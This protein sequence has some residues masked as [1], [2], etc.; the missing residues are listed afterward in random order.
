MMI[1]IRV[2]W[3]GGK[4][5]EIAST[6]FALLVGGMW[7]GVVTGRRVRSRMRRGLQRVRNRSGN[8]RRDRMPVCERIGTLSGFFQTPWGPKGW[9]FPSHT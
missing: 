8:T 2:L 9:S 7:L 1:M 3:N 6:G 5:S 4:G